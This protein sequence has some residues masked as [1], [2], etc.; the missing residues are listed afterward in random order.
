[1]RRFVLYL[2]V[3]ALA[4]P[5]TGAPSSAIAQ[6]TKWVRGTVSALAADSV[7]VKVRGKESKFSVDNRTTVV[8]R[9]AGTR[10]RAAEAEGKAGPKLSEVVK[11]GD[12]VEVRYHDMGGTLHATEIRAVSGVGEG[13]TSEDTPR[14]TT[15]SGR[16]SAV[17][18][19]S[20]TVKSGDKEWTFKVDK[21][22]TVVGRGAGTV[23]REKAS[24]GT[25]PAIT[26]VVSVNDDVS[27]SYHDM[28]GGVL[29]AGEV[30]V[31]RK[32]AK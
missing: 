12:G 23:A 21:Q 1:M 3:A 9:G 10:A 24:A 8:A 28:G 26:D 27:V 4:A 11:V 19:D 13:S 5:F 7:T 30:R 18:S 2:G 32:A 20:L 17:T 25:G 15:A 14:S 16:V 29:H 22:T 31:T 6:D